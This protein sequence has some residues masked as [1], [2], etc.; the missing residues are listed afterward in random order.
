MKMGFFIRHL[1]KYM[2]DTYREQ[3]QRSR[4]MTVLTLFRGQ[5]FSHEYFGKM[6]QCIGS[7]MAF[8]NFLSTSRDQQVSLG[9][10]QQSNPIDIAVLFLMRMDP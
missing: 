4:T 10:S 7:L 5:G 8:N 2:E 6:K 9:F 3:Q 1:H